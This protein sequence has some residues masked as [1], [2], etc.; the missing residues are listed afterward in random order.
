MRIG[1]VAIF[2]ALLSGANAWHQNLIGWR[3]GGVPC[4]VASGDGT[5]WLARLGVLC[6]P[7]WED[8]LAGSLV[9]K[10]RVY[11]PRA[12]RPS[13]EVAAEHASSALPTRPTPSP[14]TAWYDRLIAWTPDELPWEAVAHGAAKW[15]S[16]LGEL[17]L[18]SWGGQSSESATGL[19]LS[20][21]NETA[22]A[23]PMPTVDST[24]EPSS[25]APTAWPAVT[26]QYWPLPRGY[27]HFC[28]PATVTAP[29]P[30]SATQP[31][32]PTVATQLAE[33]EV[34]GAPAVTFEGLGPFVDL[35]WAVP[36]WPALM[37]RQ[38]G[39]G[40]IRQGS[41]GKGAGGSSYFQRRS[42][43]LPTRQPVAPSVR[44]PPPPKTNSSTSDNLVPPETTAK[45]AAEMQY[46]QNAIA[47]L[48]NHPNK[49]PTR[50][51]RN[52][53][54]TV[55]RTHYPK[56]RASDFDSYLEATTA[57]FEQYE[58]NSRSG[59]QIA[60]DELDRYEAAVDDAE[61]VLE[62]ASHTYSMDSTT[63]A[64]RLKALDGTRSEF[65]LDSVSEYG[66]AA[67]GVG[68][69]SASVL[70]GI[71]DIPTIFF[72]DDF[73]LRDPAMFDIATQVVLG[74]QA[75]AAE[76]FAADKSSDASAI[77]QESLS[78]YMDTVEAYLT[79]EISRR[80]PSFFAA[81]STLEELHAETDGCIGK[82]HVLRN[83]LKKVAYAQCAPGLE[84][85]RMRRRRDNI[86]A[87][88]G[89]VELLS[90]LR[91]VQPT[92]EELIGSGDCIGALNLITEAQ[93]MIELP[94]P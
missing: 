22:K 23:T 80:S 66:G 3:A 56:V 65:G 27:P 19:R 43:P 17:R 18:P 90:N 34:D 84:L 77:M 64:E 48:T 57:L 28:E 7:D 70:P 59:Y 94:G 49:A 33:L 21:R 69:N 74:P 37:S 14:P 6:P 91:H 61:K 93:D 58:A 85:V 39:I 38:P 12:T 68:G 11:P 41:D 2:A 92:V 26:T 82:I 46:G 81:L 51:H 88:L 71:E 54:P 31:A 63:M 78:A 1:T 24:T 16:W 13:N 42:Q 86:A 32:C 73:D 20:R 53:L 36:D 8:Q 25:I 29:C 52:E 79:R 47:V 76:L 89:D 72:E 55:P 40:I 62:L 9:G 35:T 45:P 75:A 30:A 10:R 67:A 83:D 44:P 50:I 87:V 15:V 5:E 4:I 60:A